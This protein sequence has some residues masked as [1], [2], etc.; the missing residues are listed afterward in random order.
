MG[1]YVGRDFWLGRARALEERFIFEARKEA[2]GW[3]WVW[4]VV[5]GVDV[6]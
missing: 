2:G 5:F 6:L 1:V 4:E 3:T